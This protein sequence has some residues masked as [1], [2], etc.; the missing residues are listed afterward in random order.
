MT[1]IFP[2]ATVMLAL[3]IVWYAGAYV[4]NAPQAINLMDPDGPHN[5]WA[6]VQ[7]A[8]NM[9]RPVLPTPGQIATNLAASI[10]GN[11]LFSP[12]NFLLQTAYTAETAVTGLAGG[13]VLGIFLAIGIVHSRV[14]DR[15]LMPWVITSQTIPILAIAPMVVVALGNIGLTGLVPKAAIV[16][17]LSFFPVTVGM[18]KGL[19]SPDAMQMDL[20]RTYNTKKM[21][22][23]VKLR[24]PVAMAFLFPS[25]RVAASLSVTGA[26]VAELP[27]G[28]QVGLGARLL[29]G[30]YYGQT[31]MMWGALV[32][33]SLLALALIGMV[34]L[35]EFWLCQ[36]RGG[37]L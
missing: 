30:S 1:R 37:R 15:S 28:A 8:W 5:F 11:P 20:M 32:L 26:I 10:F 22:L 17:Y 24:W 18:V 35:G 36:Q 3:I 6:V 31:M 12:R 4:L 16:G 23:F 9:D 33:A 21:S 25:L 34:R 14:L 2:L 19:R 7:A 13:V 27:T 29:A